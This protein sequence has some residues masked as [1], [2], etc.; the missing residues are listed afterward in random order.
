MTSFQVKLR[1]KNSKVENT[2]SSGSLTTAKMVG[3]L[4]EQQRKVK[5]LRYLEK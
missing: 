1:K 3:P 2:N 5:V 4:T